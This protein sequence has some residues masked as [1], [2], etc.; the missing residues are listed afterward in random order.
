MRNCPGG[1]CGLEGL[2]QEVGSFSQGPGRQ[3][4][5][6]GVGRSWGTRG[7]EP[8]C[9]FTTHSLALICK[10]PPELGPGCLSGRGDT[11]RIPQGVGRVWAR[12]GDRTGPRGSASSP[13]QPSDPAVLAGGGQPGGRRAVGGRVSPSSSSG[14]WSGFTVSRWPTARHAG[15]PGGSVPAQALMAGSDRTAEGCS[16]DLGWRFLGPLGASGSGASRACLRMSSA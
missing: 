7:E 3:W 4:G 5:Q 1:G 6:K 16:Q 10:V 11:G 9:K 8:Q 15:P 14:V 12:G 2:A 13:A